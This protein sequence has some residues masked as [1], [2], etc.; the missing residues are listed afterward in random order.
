MFRR[1]FSFFSMNVFLA[2]EIVSQSQMFQLQSKHFCNWNYN[3]TQYRNQLLSTLSFKRIYTTR[4]K[5]SFF[6][7]GG[8]VQKFNKRIIQFYYSILINECFL[9]L[10]INKYFLY[11][12]S[13]NHIYFKYLYSKRKIILLKLFYLFIFIFFSVCF[14]VVKCFIISFLLQNSA[15]IW[16]DFLMKAS[17]F[18]SQ[19][20]YVF[21]IYFLILLSLM[22]N[23]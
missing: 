16:E 23:V 17:K 8:G 12:D 15:P 11:L 4:M 7:L 2:I 18:H 5:N 3:S 14:K 1:L 13:N 22:R 10:I 6:C 20:R 9:G 21:C 19:L